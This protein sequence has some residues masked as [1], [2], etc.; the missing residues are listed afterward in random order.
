MTSRTDAT[1]TE[2]NPT[3]TA[4]GEHNPTVQVFA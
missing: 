4:L 3:F 2:G 1:L